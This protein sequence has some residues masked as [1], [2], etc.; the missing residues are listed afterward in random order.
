MKIHSIKLVCAHQQREFTLSSVNYVKFLADVFAHDISFSV[1]IMLLD[2][3][4]LLAKDTT[5]KKINYCN[6]HSRSL[7]LASN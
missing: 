1:R 3:L 7:L 6:L 4:I 5:L 2:Q